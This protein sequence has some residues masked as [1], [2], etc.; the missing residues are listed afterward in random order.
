M[1]I[2]IVGDIFGT[3][4]Y[5]IHTRSLAN[6]LFN[7]GIDIA[8]TCNLPQDWVRQVNDNELK[9]ISNNKDGL[10]YRLMISL[11]TI[12]PLYWNDGVPILQYVVWEG[13]KIPAGWINILR[14]GKIKHIIVPSSHTKN[15]IINSINTDPIDVATQCFIEE[16]IS[17]VPH[18]VNLTKF[19]PTNN[20]DKEFTFLADKGWPAG[21]KD[22]GGLSF[23]IKAF[24]E[25]FASKEEVKLIVKVN[26][27]YGLTQEMFNKNIYE[28]K[29]QNK[30]APKIEF[31]LNDIPYDKLNDIYNRANVFCIPSLA[32]SFH[33]G[34]LQA[35]ACGLPILYNDFGGQTDYCNE[36]NGYRLENGKMIEV[37][38]DLLYEGIS[39]KLP[40]IDE[41]KRQLRFIYN[42]QDKV[43]AK[44]IVALE[45]SKEYT[46]Q[47][48]AKKL[49]QFLL[50][51]E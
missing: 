19:F 51:K 46:W 7:E 35:M 13:N 16:K 18:G 43:K 23:L 22:R 30:D 6:A 25:E 24:G 40:D 1:K 50:A 20:K 12:A 21:S 3:T 11:P 8:L 27:S 2:E 47:N 42:N 17:I 29:L 9:M 38:W 41:I 45:T 34:G 36:K 49:I 15:A 33:I 48:S 26:M 37:D 28:L 5:A 14:E 4:G 39:W 44:S 32:E 10:D 31:I